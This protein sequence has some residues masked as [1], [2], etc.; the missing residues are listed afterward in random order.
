M[1]ENRVIRKRKIWRYLQAFW[2]IH[3]DYAL[4]AIRRMARAKN[5]E[6]MLTALVEDGMF[7]EN[8]M[9]TVAL[10]SEILWDC[11]ADLDT[12]MSEVA[13]R[14]YVDFA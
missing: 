4:E 14:G 9:Y 11:E 10:H 1:K 8:I 3:A 13:L 12:L 2:L 6:L 7:E 5:G